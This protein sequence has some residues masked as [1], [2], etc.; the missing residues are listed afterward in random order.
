MKCEEYSRQLS[1]ERDGRL[2]AAEREALETHLCACRACA[3]RADALDAL[4]GEL[5]LLGRTGALK[6]R[7]ADALTEDIMMALALESHARARTALVRQNR[8]ES[9]KVW[10]FSHSV[11]AFVSVALLFFLSS[12]VLRPWHRTM[13]I[14]RALETT[15]TPGNDELNQLSTVLLPAPLSRPGF[16]PTGELLCFSEKSPEGEFVI[17]VE[18]DMN[19][20]ASIVKVG[21]PQASDGLNAEML[22]RLSTVLAHHASFTPARREGKYITADAVLMFSKVN[23]QG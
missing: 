19:G 13:S 18:V 11:G 5:S 21:E 7:E 1:A 2:T 4:R 14:R 6:R 16:M 12:E 15:V 8:R 23:I 10:A 22:D 17:A 9:L 20:R 3:V